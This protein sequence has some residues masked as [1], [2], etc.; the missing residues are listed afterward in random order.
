[1]SDRHRRPRPCHRIAALLLAAGAAAP[2]LGQLQLMPA[3]PLGVAAVS[4][5][6]VYLAV[7]RIDTALSPP[8]ATLREATAAADLGQRHVLQ[9]DGPMTPERRAA[10]EAA[11]VALGDYLPANAYI[12]ELAGADPDAVAA[13]GFVRWHAPFENAWKLSDEIAGFQPTTVERIQLEAQGRLALIVT[14]FEGEDPQ[15]AADAVFGRIDSAQVFY[16]ESLGGQGELSVAIDAADLDRLAEIPEVQFVENAPEFTKR[17]SSVRWIG[18]SNVINQTPVYDAGITGAGEVIAV[19]DGRIDQNHCSFSGGKII[20]YNTSAGSDDHGTHVAGTAAGNGGVDNDTRGM[21]YD[22]NIVFDTIPSFT[23]SAFYAVASQHHN[24]GARIH[25]NSWGDDGTT[26]YNSLCRGIDRFMHDFEDSLILF[27]VTNTSTLRNPDNSKNLLACGAT[28]DTPSQQLHCTGGVGPTADGRRKPEAYLPGCGILSS[29]WSTS[30]STVSLSGTS[31]ATPAIAGTCAL[32]RQ[33]YREGFYPSGLASAPDAIS[34]TAALVKATVLNSTVDMTGVTGYPSNLEGWGRVLLD[35][36][37]Y[38]DGDTRTLVVEDVRNADGLSTGES[39][40]VLFDVSDTGEPLKVTLVWTEPPASASTGSGPAWINDLNLELIAP[41][42]TTVYKGNVFAGG[43]SV[44]GGAFD[45]RNNVEMALIDSPSIGSWTARIT[46]AAVNQGPQ[47]YALVAT[48][49]LSLGPTPLRMFLDSS[50]PGLQPLGAPVDVRVRIEA[51]DDTLVPDSARLLYALDGSSYQ[52]ATL[53]PLG[54][55]LYEATVPAS[56]SCDD[57]PAF[58]VRAEG[59]ATGVV[60]LPPDGPTDPLGYALGEVATELVAAFE[61][62]GDNGWARDVAGDTATAGLW[63]RMDPEQTQNTGGDIAQPEDDFTDDGSLCWVT[64][65]AAGSSLGANDIDGGA[66]SLLTPVFDLSDLDNANVSY[67]RWYSNHT[68][69]TPNTDTMVVEISDDAGASW[70][71]LETVGPTEQADGGWFTA[72]FDIGSVVSLT[73]TVQLRFTASDVSPGSIVEAAIDDFVITTQ[74]CVPVPTE[75]VGDVDGDNDTDV[76]DFSAL[77]A[78]FGT[79]PGDANWNPD[80]DIVA[81]GTID[82]FD[83]SEQSANFGCDL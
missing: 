77:A 12:A 11:G 22:A 60:T 49:A 39:A 82:V 17:N 6:T 30:C 27:A 61:D 45:D 68:G 81:D 54:E 76:F 53:T 16:A 1:M 37:L 46:G 7:G 41:D 4:D 63:N 51:G 44:T 20:A 19:V 42:G 48:G 35:N 26:A 69:A 34:P 47:G 64:D 66:T 80:A 28:S 5:T 65:G 71:L 3:E 83:F 14:L 55:N 56:N 36:A 13:L 74:V 2:A 24:Q 59:A 70:T 38:F 72:S 79:Q 75:C 43:Q 23:D 67:A 33:Y 21:A 62:A 73:S 52:T 58:Y 31:M 57:A 18:Q 9:L 29:R 32:A 10:L 15:A 25:T 8:A 40:D 50:V 78:A